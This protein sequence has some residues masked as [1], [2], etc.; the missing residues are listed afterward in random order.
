MN[1]GEVIIEDVACSGLPPGVCA[2][3]KAGGLI[4]DDIRER[5]D[6]CCAFI[7]DQPTAEKIRKTLD[8]CILVFMRKR[9]PE[10]WPD[11]ELSEKDVEKE[12]DSWRADM[13]RKL[14]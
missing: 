14:S 13:V 5:A 7:P 6:K 4:D 2:L 9:V 8:D 1:L 3:L 10:L 12:L 11:C